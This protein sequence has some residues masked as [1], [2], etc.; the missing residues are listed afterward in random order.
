MLNL[1]A[2]LSQL[3]SIGI[4]DA[5]WLNLGNSGQRLFKFAFLKRQLFDK[6]GL[7][8]SPTFGHTDRRRR[9]RGPFLALSVS[10]TRL[11]RRSSQGSA[12]PHFLTRAER[13]EEQSRWLKPEGGR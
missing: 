13:E 8:F 7:M 10:N 3:Y 4:C 6:M 2:N 5:Q 1:A 12:H 11:S 9:S